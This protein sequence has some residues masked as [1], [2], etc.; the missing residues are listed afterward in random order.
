MFAEFLNWIDLIWV[1]IAFFVVAK[2]HRWYAVAFILSCLM[3]MRMQ[4]ELIAEWG[5]G[6]E[7]FPNMLLDSPPYLRGVVVYSL[8]FV[9]YLL[10]SHYSR[11]TAPVIYMAAS[12]SIF[13][14]AFVFSFI[15][16]SL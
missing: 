16:M 13:F 7:G 10:L 12:I 5:F 3:V 15:V 6:T 2:P 8:V 1:P 14:V 4:Y 11:K 9:L